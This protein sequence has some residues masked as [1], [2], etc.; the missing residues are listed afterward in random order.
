MQLTFLRVPCLV[1]VSLLAMAVAPAGENLYWPGHFDSHLYGGIFSSQ[2]NVT[3]TTDANHTPGGKGA[4]RLNG[5]AYQHLELLVPG[6]GRYVLSFWAKA[7]R[8]T[9]L[10][11]KVISP[12]ERDEA[13]KIKPKET[14]TPI[15][16]EPSADWK[17]Y[18]VEFVTTEPYPGPVQTEVLLGC[19]NPGPAAYVDDVSIVAVGEQAKPRVGRVTEAVRSGGFET[20]DGWSALPGHGKLPESAIWKASTGERG[21]VLTA[22]PEASPGDA[23]FG[24]TQDLDVQALRGK[25]IRVSAEV[26]FL[27]LDMPL[28]P[29]GGVLFV[30]ETGE[31]TVL[32]GIP[33][34]LWVPVGQASPAGQ[35]KT[36]QGEYR[37]PAEADSLRLRIQ[38]QPAMGAN[39][40]VVRGVRVEVLE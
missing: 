40:A 2:I 9:P 19:F 11:L 8:P 37:I 4:W 20:T 28:E 26:Q 35:W 34:P 33:N 16:I 5:N 3:V 30:L 22:K 7:E 31:G 38:G 24:V 14:V 21:V 13:G 18:E 29:W 39:R 25:T 27:T 6:R 32:E 36:V 15:P 23:V 12:G 1:A 17:R 10:E